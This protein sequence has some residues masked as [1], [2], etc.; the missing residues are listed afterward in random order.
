VRDRDALA[1][2][3]R[4]ARP[5]PSGWV[6]GVGYHEAV[7]GPLD[8]EALDALIADAPVRVQHRSGALWCVN[9]AGIGLLGLD[10]GS[11]APGVERDGRGR[12]TGRLYR[13]DAWLR[14]QL[15]L[16]QPPSLS[17]VGRE[18][19]A[20][21]VTG[22]TDATPGNGPGSLRA[23]AAALVGGELAQRVMVMGG[24]DLPEPTRTAAKAGLSRGARKLLL[25]E[26]ALPSLEE[27]TEAVRA[28]HAGGRAVAI[29]CVTR[30]ELVLA[31]AAL[32][33]AGARP[34]DRIEHA[35]VA[36]PDAAREL[37]PLGVTVV[38]QPGFV[39]ER[40][41]AYA[42]EVEPRD[43]PWLW[44]CQGL[45]DAGLRVG[46]GTDAPF[47]EPDPWRA[48]RAAVLRRS[49]AGLVLGADEAVSP[50]RALALFTTPPEDPG[51]PPR[52]VAPG[53]PADLVLLDAP[54]RAAREEL[55]AG[56]VRATLR[57]GR[58]VWR[59]D[60]APGKI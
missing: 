22:V 9:S 37:V 47:G 40:G 35:A 6:R 32:G 4:G 50:E 10:L 39:H 53:A 1:R 33:A 13:L 41:D 28:A 60:A 31:G 7:A 38:T 3:L 46:G 44:R 58:I 17:D 49:E 26:D 11:D 29:H 57:A 14:E 45:L 42:A 55:D 27:L 15:G 19:A 16:T 18:L 54:W 21:G 20:F 25:H 8:R 12:A 59:R 24:A 43:R 36:P 56:R 2:A 52:R 51:G 34:G 30:A 5:D 48:M 23:L